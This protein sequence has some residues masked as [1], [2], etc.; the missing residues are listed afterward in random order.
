MMNSIS[1][2]FPR[3]EAIELMFSEYKDYAHMGVD[4]VQRVVAIPPQKRKGPRG[5]VAV[6]FPARLFNMLESAAMEGLDEI[7]S[8]QPHGRSFLVHDKASF[9]KVML[10]R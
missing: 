5:G 7:V 4:E 3:D 10:P 8:W 6:P 1:G 9:V 2:S